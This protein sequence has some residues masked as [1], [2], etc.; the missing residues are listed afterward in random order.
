MLNN[1]LNSHQLDLIMTMDS[2]LNIGVALMAT[3]M[4]D[5]AMNTMDL[6]M[7]VEFVVVHLRMHMDCCIHFGSMVKLERSMDALV[8]IADIGLGLV[9]RCVANIA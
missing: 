9:E 5:V 7:L 6:P 8:S 1:W 3:N 4:N 2:Y